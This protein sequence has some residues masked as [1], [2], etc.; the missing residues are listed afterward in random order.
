M[1]SEHAAQTGSDSQS[2]TL[3]VV[4][5]FFQVSGADWGSTNVDKGGMSCLLFAEISSKGLSRDFP[6]A[7]QGLFSVK[8]NMYSCGP[9]D[10]CDSPSGR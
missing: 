5:C 9:W 6:E 7:F 1:L 2:I 4:D 8:I 10:P 3:I